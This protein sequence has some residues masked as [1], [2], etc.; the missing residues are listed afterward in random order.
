[1]TQASS[2]CPKSISEGAVLR[3][4]AVVGN[5]GSGKTTVARTLAARLGVPHV[6][7][8]ALNWRPGWE[9]ASAEEFRAEVDEATR[10]EGWV[11]DGNYFGRLGESVLAH[12]DLVVWLDPPLRTILARLTRRTVDRI[13]S[14]EEMWGTNRETFRGAFLSRNSL[15]VWALKMHFRKRAE[16]A[17]VIARYPH[18][19]LCSAREADEWLGRLAGTRT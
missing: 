3:R 13:R 11:V 17:K 5:T 10:G 2:P 19:R 9:M 16:R 4:V 15:F 8:D 1:V 6:E 18:V 12:A 14:G 7:L